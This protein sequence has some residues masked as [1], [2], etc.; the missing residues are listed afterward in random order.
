MKPARY[1]IKRS[2]KNLVLLLMLPAFVIYW[3]LSGGG[4]SDSAF[5]SFSQLISLFPGK[6]GS[7]FRAAFYRLA[8][9]DTSDEI[10][11]GFLTILS[12]KNTTIHKGVYIGPQCNIG[13]CTIGKD[14]LIGSGVHIL[15]GNEQHRFSDPEVPIQEQG[16]S[17]ERIVVGTDCWIGNSC[18]VL[19]SIS[20]H[21]I[22]AAAAVVVSEFEEGSILAGLPA[23]KISSRPS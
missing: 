7:Y 8:C 21:C 5:Q 2:I 14:T 18:V 15:S 13:M 9:P 12:H 23:K 22:V 3:I 19:S 4:K 10:S 1:L 17:F 11:I 16:G 6:T 20:N